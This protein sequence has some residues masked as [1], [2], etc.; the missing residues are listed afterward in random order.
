M[1]D[2]WRKD[3]CRNTVLALQMITLLSRHGL[4]NAGRENKF[5]KDRGSH[6]TAIALA[7]KYGGR[8]LTFQNNLTRGSMIC[9]RKE[10]QT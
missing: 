7:N 6:R 8:C 1:E 2:I 9:G 3:I 10:R 4:L 5:I